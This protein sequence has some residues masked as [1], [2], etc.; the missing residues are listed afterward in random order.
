MTA[1]VVVRPRWAVLGSTVPALLW[2][3]GR[4]MADPVTV[5]AYCACGVPSQPIST[6]TAVVVVSAGW[7]LMLSIVSPR[8][9]PRAIA[10]I[11]GSPMSTDTSA[12]LVWR[13]APP[14]KLITRRSGVRRKPPIMTGLVISSG[15]RA[16][17]LAFPVRSCVRINTSDLFALAKVHV[18]LVRSMSLEI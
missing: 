5:T 4:E 9:L 1:I 12:T 17:I 3:V 11:R 14:A 8:V 7:V 2:A 18:L 10:K 15:P 13:P 6:R 16:D